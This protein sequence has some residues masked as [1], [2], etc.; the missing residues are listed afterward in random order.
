MIKG[1]VRIEPDK[2]QRNIRS[3]IFLLLY[4]LMSNLFAWNVLLRIFIFLNKLAN[5]NIAT[6]GAKIFQLIYHNDMIITGMASL[7]AVFLWLM[8]DVFL[9]KFLFK[10]SLGVLFVLRF[11]FVVI[12]LLLVFLFISIYHYHSRLFTDVFEYFY[13]IKW[14]F[15]NKATI[16]LFSIGV[17]VASGINFFKAIRQ[18]IGY[19]KFF[20]IISGYYRIPREENRIFIFIDLISSTKYAELLGHKKYS[21]FIQECF[22]EIGILEIKYRA[23]QYQFV[24]DEVVIS[25][26]ARNENNYRNAVNFFYEFKSLLASR[27][28]FFKEEFGIIPN[29]T[30]SINAG[31]IMIAEVGTLKSEIAFHG[32]VLNT[33]ARIQKQCKSYNRILLVTDN[34]VEKFRPI[35]QGYQIEWITNDPLVGKLKRVGVY[36]V[37]PEGE[38]D[39]QFENNN[40]MTNFFSKH[41]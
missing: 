5:P 27:D 3:R 36:A 38:S 8:E 13:L 15:F 21:A 2:Q 19:E 26:A 30:A 16:Y 7:A 18:K 14:F 34:F 17:I 12:M 41:C 25:W 4:K 31:E 10:K 22:K 9:Y 29:F 32:D 35:S 37:H 1:K 6:E 23:M 20:H 33:A 28:K 11:V 24:G 40:E 39:Y